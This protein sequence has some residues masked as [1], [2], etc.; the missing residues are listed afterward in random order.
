M[1]YRVICGTHKTQERR[2]ALQV[3][4]YMTKEKKGKKKREE[5]GK[6]KERKKGPLRCLYTE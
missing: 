4:Y 3:W 1:V 2:D 5:R 6:G